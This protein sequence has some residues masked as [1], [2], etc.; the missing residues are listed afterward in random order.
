MVALSAMARRKGATAAAGWPESIRALPRLAWSSAISGRAAAAR[1]KW[2]AARPGRP[3]WAAWRPAWFSRW[4]TDLSYWG[5]IAVEW[6]EARLSKA[7]FRRAGWRESGG[8]RRDRAR[9][10]GLGRRDCR[11]NRLRGRRFW[12]G[13]RRSRADRRAGR[14]GRGG[15]LS[16]PGRRGRFAR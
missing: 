7:E 4:A 5:V 14:R 10:S 12:P 13:G 16:P 3:A 2:G 8:G 6:W 1:A 11:R 9:R 15:F